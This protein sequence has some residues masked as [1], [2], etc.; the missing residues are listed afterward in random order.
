MELRLAVIRDLPKLK[1]VYKKIIDHMNENHIDIWDDIYPCE[2]FEK[3]I[4]SNSLYVLQNKNNDIV[5]AFALCGSNPGESHVEWEDNHGKAVY[6]DR[7]GVNTNYFRQGIGTALLQHAME[8]AKQ[9]SAE[10]LRLFVIDR[11]K[12]ALNLYLKNG[13]TKASGTYVEVIDEDLA[14]T[15]YGFEKKIESQIE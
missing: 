9:Q 8:I 11:N 13:F 4:N 6:L 5:G 14:F 15:E 7:L 2:F 1:E 10:Y 3:D 12:P